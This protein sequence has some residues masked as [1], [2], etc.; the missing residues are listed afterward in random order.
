VVVEHRLRALLPLAALVDQRVTQPDPGAQIDQM[1]GRD[2]TLRHPADHHQL[3]Q[4][5]GVGAV[6]LGAL[7]APA[8]LGSLC[9]LG[10]LHPR[11]ERAQLG[12][13]SREGGV[14]EVRPEHGVGER[15]I[16]NITR[17]KDAP[18]LRR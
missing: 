12:H 7:L 6:G 11:P 9:R 14:R 15:M 8:S 5:P 18:A 10:Q 17:H 3:T 4:T 2:P 16:A 1:L 13:L